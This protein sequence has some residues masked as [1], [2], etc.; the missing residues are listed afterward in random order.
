MF[1]ASRGSLSHISAGILDPG[2]VAIPAPRPGLPSE[3]KGLQD[4]RWHLP[5]Q[6]MVTRIQTNSWAN[7]HNANLNENGGRFGETNSW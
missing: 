5:Q 1:W 4:R 2:Q 6:G 7:D 3:L